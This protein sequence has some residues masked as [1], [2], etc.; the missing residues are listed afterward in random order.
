MTRRGLLRR[1]AA[2]GLGA[3]ALGGTLGSR[4]VAAQ[5]SS[6]PVELTIWLEGEPGTVTAVTEIIDEYMQENPNVTVETHIRRQRPLQPDAR[7]RAQRR[8]G[9]GHLGWAAP[10]R[11]SRQPSSRPGTPS[12]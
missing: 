2:L 1:G 5:E 12:T 4:A 7:A 9:A 6:E 8:R 3:S 10:A 11:V